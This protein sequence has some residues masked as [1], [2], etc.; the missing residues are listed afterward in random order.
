MAYHVGI[1]LLRI[2]MKSTTRNML[3]GTY[4]SVAIFIRSAVVASQISKIPRNATKI[5][6]YSSSWSSKVIDLGGNR[7]R[8]CK[9][10]LLI[11]SN[12]GRNS[13]SFEKL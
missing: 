2:T 8:I 11:N 3:I 10:L 4:N 13:Y 1:G 7:K 12:Y 5:R 9:F 6:T